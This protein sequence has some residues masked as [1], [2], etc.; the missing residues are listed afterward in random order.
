MRLHSRIIV[1]FILC[2][3]L[4]AC[5]E[6]ETAD[7]K[8]I[9]GDRSENSPIDG[10]EDLESDDRQT[11]G[12]GDQESEID[13]AAGDGEPLISDGDDEQEFETDSGESAD[14]EQETETHP[15]AD[16]LFRFPL[17]EDQ[18]H[19]SEDFI[20]HVD[21]DPEVH[22]GLGTAICTNYEDGHFPYCY[23]EHKGTDWML[24][25]K[26]ETMDLEI[27][28]V[29]AAADGKVIHVEDGHYDRCHTDHDNL[30][31]GNIS[32]DGNPIRANYI[33]IEHEGGVVTKY[34]HLKKNSML[35]EAEDEV[36]CGQPLALVGSS[37]I[38]V[39]P[40]LHFQV[41]DAE[42]EIIDPFAGV[43]SQAESYWVVQDRGN[44]LPV[45]ICP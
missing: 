36:I 12:D 43:R 38:S 2:L 42:G 27:A 40:H 23:D 33:S 45:E 5:F 26:F 13:G 28:F 32:C 34:Y 37:G 9:D 24:Q 16:I 44:H 18:G 14:G 19:Y 31:A 3:S 10:D 39:A 6:G 41:E 4:P 20:F 25:G 17:A 35:V 7:Q 29:Y 11:D 8:S 21:H 22:E 1:I 30:G 15:K